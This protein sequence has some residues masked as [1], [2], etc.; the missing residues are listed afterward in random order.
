MMRVLAWKE[1]RELAAVWVMLL[2][3]TT[4][5]LYAGWLSV[6]GTVAWPAEM[7]MPAAVGLCVLVGASGLV[8]GALLLAS[9]TEAGTQAFLDTLPAYRFQ[10]LRIKLAVGLILAVVQG[11]LAAG[12]GVLVGLDPEPLPLSAWLWLLPAVACVGLFWGLV[13][14]ALCRKV[15]AAAVVGAVLLVVF[16]VPLATGTAFAS[17]WY[18]PELFPTG[19]ALA[20]VGTTLAV[21]ALVALPWCFRVFCRPDRERRVRGERAARLVP[22]LPGVRRILWLALRQGGIMVLFLDLAGFAAGTFLPFAGFILWPAATLA[23]SVLCGLAAFGPEQ[24]GG[25]YRF[26]GDRRLPLGRVWL[27]NTAW[28]FVLNVVAAVFIPLGGFVRV[29]MDRPA[30][31]RGITLTSPELWDHVFGQR[32]ELWGVSL[33]VLLLAWLSYGFAIGQLVSLLTRNRI[34]AAVVALVLSAGVVACWVPSLTVGDVAAWQLLGGPILLLMTACGAMWPWAT[35]RLLTR[36]AALGLAGGVLL[37]AAWMAGSLANR[38]FGIPDGSDPVDL[39]AYRRAVGVARQSG[40]GT[41]IRRAADGFAAE[42]PRGK[43]LR[44]HDDLNQV[45][46]EVAQTGR[47]DLDPGVLKWEL[48]ELF[49]RPW[50][51]DLKE[52]AALPPGLLDVPAESPR[53][54]RP[55]ALDNCRLMNTYLMARARQLEAAHDP[56][57][58]VEPVVWALAMS[59]TL[60]HYALGPAYRLGDEV[61][62]DA[63]QGVQHWLGAVGGKSQLLRRALAALTRHEAERPPLTEYLEAEYVNLRDHLD[64]VPRAVLAAQR[65]DVPWAQ[66]A[67]LNAAWQTPWERARVLRLIDLGF[68]RPLDLAA[69]PY[70]QTPQ[71]GFTLALDADLAER[72]AGPPLTAKLFSR[73]PPAVDWPN[74][75]EEALKLCYIRAAR[76]QAALALYKLRAGKS[77]AAL[78]DLVPEYLDRIPLDPF[79][80][81]AFHYRISTGEWVREVFPVDRNTWVPEGRGMVWSVGPDGIDGG[82]HTTVGEVLWLIPVLRLPGYDVLFIVPH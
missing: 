11:V 14:S 75:A 54:G 6:A 59:R 50:V 45:A 73:P 43:K 78:S 3:V 20:C 28:W 68:R 66:A 81:Q 47:A 40:A 64:D 12:L 1:V 70:W 22:G 61:E 4:G 34:V 46:Q 9:E 25:T 44:E 29:A 51:S 30:G 60:R 77:A 23:A 65:A 49:A 55:S 35:E 13:G 10:Q 69:S 37:A 71:R 67:V 33:A 82:G 24:V 39:P 79:N 18:W 62:S 56:A 5:V 41:L 57:H 16:D 32:L 2:A 17:W 72:Y 63:L 58:A 31:F 76:L 19:P 7:V 38:V 42:A 36:R 15:F 52:A 74:R 27:A 8:C 26:L 48:D 80:G 53:P 21:S